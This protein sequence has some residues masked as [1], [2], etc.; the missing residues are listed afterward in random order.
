MEFLETQL[1]VP[2][3][4]MR[5]EEAMV[6]TK[7]GARGRADIV[8]YRDDEKNNPLMV[9]ECKAPEVDISCDE[10]REQAERYRNILKADYIMLVNGYKLIIYKYQ[11]GKNF[12]LVNISS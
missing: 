11:D 6:H 7:R 9:I 4:R 10:V 12:E 3:N 5:V 2:L 1:G 8:V